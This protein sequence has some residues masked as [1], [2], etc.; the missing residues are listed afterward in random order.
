MTVS[1][2]LHRLVKT[3]EP[4]VCVGPTLPTASKFPERRMLSL[5]RDVLFQAFLSLSTHLLGYLSPPSRP[6]PW[7]LT[8]EYSSLGRNAR[9]L[10]SAALRS[11]SSCCI[12]NSLR[13]LGFL[14]HCSLQVVLHTFL[15]L[16]FHRYLYC[17]LSHFAFPDGSVPSSH[18]SLLLTPPLSSLMLHAG[19]FPPRHCRYL[20]MDPGA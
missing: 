12:S 17:F 3:S 7:F 5:P 8:T 15:S 19:Y 11:S 9:P 4:C 2:P 16:P 1:R 13:V 20:R 10:A 6:Y 18:Y 14:L